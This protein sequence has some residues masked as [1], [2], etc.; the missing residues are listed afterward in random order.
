MVSILMVLSTVFITPNP[1]SD[2]D[3]FVTRNKNEADL[4]VWLTDNR[5]FSLKREEYWTQTKNRSISNFTIRYVKTKS[6]SDIVVFF[7]R[8]RYESGW[9]KSHHLRGRLK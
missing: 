1:V 2:Y 5:N 3:V 8:N 4:I 6:Q 9:R 7:T